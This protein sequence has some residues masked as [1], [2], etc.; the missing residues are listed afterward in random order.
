MR[1][2]PIEVNGR[3]FPSARAAARHIVAMELMLG[4]ERKENTV[5]KELKRTFIKNGSHSWAMYGRW[6]VK[7]CVIVGP[8]AKPKAQARDRCNK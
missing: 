7:A 2:I 8:A 6:A 1:A 5:V 4:N 3:Q